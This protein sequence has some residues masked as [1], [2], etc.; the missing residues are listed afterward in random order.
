MVSAGVVSRF[1]V[2]SLSSTIHSPFETAMQEYLADLHIHSRF[3]R[4]TSKK[5]C[6]PLLAAWARLKGLGVLGTGDFTHPKWREELRDTLIFDEASGLYVL[7]N[8]AAVAS[9]LPELPVDAAHTRIFLPDEEKRVEDATGIALPQVHF[10]L[11]GEISSIYKRDEKVRKVHNLV[12]MPDLESAERFSRRLQEIGNLHSDGRPI[13][14]LDSRDLLEMVLE[15]HPQAFLVPAHI[16]TPWFSIFG[17]KSGF[18]RLEDCFGDLSPEIFALETGLS[19]DPAMNRL[20]SALDDYRLVSNSDAHSG[21]NL[22]REANVFC[23]EISYS[24]MLKALRQPLE[25]NSTN[26][27]G[28]L[29]FFPEEGKYHMDGHRKCDVLLSP[30]ETKKLGGICPVCNSPVTVGVLNRVMELADRHEPVYQEGGKQDNGENMLGERAFASLVP[31]PEILSEILGVGA[32]SNKVRDLY[33][34]VL[35][36]FGPELTILRQTPEAELARF[37]PSLAEAIG[38]MRRAEVQLRGGFDGEYGVVRMFTKEEQ[39][40]IALGAGVFGGKTGKKGGLQGLTLPGTALKDSMN[41]T[42]QEQAASD[43]AS[44]TPDETFSADDVASAPLPEPSLD[45]DDDFIFEP[46]DALA[47]EEEADDDTTRLPGLNIEQSKA[48]TIGH[49]PVLVLAGPGTGKTRT[50]IARIAHLMAQGTDPQKIAAV[51]FTRRAATEMQRRLAAKLDTESILPKADT[52]HALA[53][54]VWH[55]AF[56]DMPLILSEES[57]RRVFDE[58]N[59]DTGK[60]VRNSAWEALNTARESISVLPFDYAHLEQRYSDMKRAANLVDYTDL[61][62]FWLARIGSGV[63]QCPWD[64]VLVDEA[65]DLSLLQLRLIRDLLPKNGE[66]FFGIGDPDQSIYSFRGAHGNSREFFSQAW[67]DMECIHLASNYRSFKEI[68]AVSHA[69]LG[70]QASG[71]SLTPERQ[72]SGQVSFF[73]APSPESEAIWIADQAAALVGLGS[74]TLADLHR[75]GGRGRTRT[76]EDHSPGDI[77]ILVRTHALGSSYRAALSRKGIPV[78]EPAMDVFWSDERVKLILQEAGRGLGIAPGPLPPGKKAHMPPCPPTVLTKGPLAISVYL[79]DVPPFDSFFWTSRAFKGLLKAW[80]KHKNWTSLL[81]WVHQ[82]TELEMVRAKGEKVQVISIHAA[83]GLEFRT[84]FLPALED[85]ILPFIGAGLF[86]GKPT[87]KMEPEHILEEQRL[88]YVALSRAKD[89]LF[90]SCAKKRTL[91]GRQV[92]LKPSRF[93]DLLPS[94]LLMS[95]TLVAESRQKAKQLKLI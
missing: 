93:L 64:H 82:S 43:A 73:L 65:Q 23:G 86:T 21:E 55:T 37:L 26:F 68:L 49:G 52:L 36:K 76:E 14:G 83:K 60:Q 92:Q 53:T 79:T 31:L 42:R 22:G 32:K 20:W 13:L 16:W 9:M 34:K 77:A 7:N 24:G 70:E 11:Q 94:G 91:Y 69:G 78:A 67:P 19:S 88:F 38:R 81:N 39:K 46:A 45:D 10:M 29:E 56:G 1:S 84:V 87:E 51:T 5:L 89:F 8:P 72:G 50:L 74:H 71:S 4:A 59:A 12:F 35:E 41:D 54:G 15:T 25:Q 75:T 30:T 62:E 63:Y 6:I 90:L 61:L 47:P 80:D 3:S 48:V 95:S 28:T 44:D 58:A 17:S 85:G 27:L 40:E 57:A 33:A 18:D 2:C 66:G